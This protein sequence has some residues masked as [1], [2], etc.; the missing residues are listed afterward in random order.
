LTG[1]PLRNVAAAVLI[2][3]AVACVAAC[4]SDRPDTADAA[5]G[6]KVPSQTLVFPNAS[7][8]PTT[9]ALP[10]I[11]PR[12][13]TIAPVSTET[14]IPGQPTVAPTVPPTAPPTT[15]LGAP[16]EIEVVVQDI[17]PADAGYV[18]T[19]LH[20]TGPWATIIAHPQD[21]NVSTDELIV[22]HADDGL[23]SVVAGGGDTSCTNAGIP[24][25]LF[26]PLACARW[27]TG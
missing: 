12:G 11:V 27:E 20:C 24:P 4:S 8:R 19:E 7:G 15:V 26:G 14:T 17:G 3:V 6:V 13:S 25:E 5:A 23:W 16:C 2:P 18:F 21:P 1:A 9:T 10:T 22:M